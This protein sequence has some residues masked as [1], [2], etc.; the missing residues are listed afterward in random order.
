[1]S[2][3]GKTTDGLKT[4]KDLDAWNKAMELVESV[5]AITSK[6]PKEET[7]GLT[8][9]IRRSAIS[10]PSNIAEGAARNS[11]KE[12]IQYLHI[13]L[14][15]LAELDTQLILGDRLKFSENNQELSQVAQLR[16]ILLGLLRHLKGKLA[17]SE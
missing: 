15:S 13:A 4:H 9:Q 12:F 17:E 3:E 14:G 5:Y 10:I 1:M 6:Y 8:L 7:Y 2:K 16:Q 11:K